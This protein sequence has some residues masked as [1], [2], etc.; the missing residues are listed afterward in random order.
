MQWQE[1]MS[2][3]RDMTIEFLH[4]EIP[5]GKFKEFVIECYNDGILTH[6]DKEHLLGLLSIF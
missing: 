2:K 1:G 4:K 3:L 5:R 6:G